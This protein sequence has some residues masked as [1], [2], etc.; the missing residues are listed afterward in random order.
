M[1]TEL[2]IDTPTLQSDDRPKLGHLLT[3]YPDYASASLKQ[4]PRICVGGHAIGKTKQ[5]RMLSDGRVTYQGPGRLSHNQI[6]YD[7]GADALFGADHTLSTPKRIR[8]IPMVPPRSDSEVHSAILNHARSIWQR[9]A[10][11]GYCRTDETFPLERF[12]RKYGIVRDYDISQY[13]TDVKDDPP[14]TNKYAME[15]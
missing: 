7:R 1:R 13:I 5:I 8:L 9:T 11:D 2:L 15:R 3:T 14:K 4:E 12:D 6:Y 10:C